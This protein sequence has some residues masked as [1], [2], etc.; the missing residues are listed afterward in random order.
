MT[1]SAKTTK[2]QGIIED[3]LH[4]SPE[5][6]VSAENVEQ[7]I[8]QQLDNADVKFLK[9]LLAADLRELSSRHQKY[10]LTEGVIDTLLRKGAERRYLSFI[11]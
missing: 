11:W 1:E 7:L 5:G 6:A 9:C 3:I 4:D 2:V 10:A 8:E